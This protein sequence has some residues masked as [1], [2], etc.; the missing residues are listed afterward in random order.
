MVGICMLSMEKYR[1][2][3]TLCI[4]FKNA[5]NSQNGAE[6]DILFLQ[7]QFLLKHFFWDFQ[8]K[9]YEN[10]E[11]FDKFQEKTKI[12]ITCVL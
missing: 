2:N 4:S 11:I 1:E 10:F 8:S 7:I 9:Y 12:L 3:M 5:I 6:Y